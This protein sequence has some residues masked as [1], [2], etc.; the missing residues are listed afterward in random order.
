MVLPRPPS[1]SVSGVC[2]LRLISEGLDLGVGVGIW[3]VEDA[4]A[5]TVSLSLPSLSVLVLMLPSTS[6]SLSYSRR[7]ALSIRIELD[8][9]VVFP[10]HASSPFTNA[11]FSSFSSIDE[12]DD[13]SSAPYPFVSPSSSRLSITLQGPIALSS[14]FQFL[15]E[16][17]EEEEEEEVP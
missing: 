6:T 17:E 14:I 13:A 1:P 4:D 2:L 8:G 15:W 12:N 16:K 10:P 5:N 7:R 11:S 9:D 3:Y